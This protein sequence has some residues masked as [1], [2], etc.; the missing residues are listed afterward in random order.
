[1][2]IYLNQLR[3]YYLL[4]LVFSNWKWFLKNNYWEYGTIQHCLRHF[5]FFSQVFFF[6]YWVFENRRSI[7][8]RKDLLSL[9]LLMS[10]SS[11]HD[12]LIDLKFFTIVPLNVIIFPIS[13]RFFFFRNLFLNLDLFMIAL[14]SSFVMKG[15]SLPRTYQGLF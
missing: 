9:I 4:N 3:R 14:C 12:F 6:V 1:M 8:S 2:L 10:K 7:V 15:A 13:N 11:K 5:S